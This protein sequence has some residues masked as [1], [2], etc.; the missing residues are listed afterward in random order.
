MNDNRKYCK[1]DNFLWMTNI[2]RTK[3]DRIT[4]LLLCWKPPLRTNLNIFYDLLL[5]LVFNY[6][7]FRQPIS[8]D[9]FFSLVFNNQC[10]HKSFELIANKSLLIWTFFLTIIHVYPI[11][12]GFTSQLEYRRNFDM[13][14]FSLPLSHS[15]VTFHSYI[16]CHIKSVGFVPQ[17]EKWTASWN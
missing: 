16:Q 10:F 1:L 12:C 15:L 14:F 13:R 17:I 7:I 8:D 9:I 2:Y 5:F 4:M 6:N 3:I 11:L